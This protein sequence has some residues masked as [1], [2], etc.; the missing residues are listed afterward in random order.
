MKYSR[1]KA[2][3]S[4][5]ACSNTDDK[6]SFS[7]YADRKV[8]TG[9]SPPTFS[10]SSCPKRLTEVYA[11]H[12]HVQSQ[13]CEQVAGRLHALPCA[14]SEDPP[15][16]LDAPDG[17]KST[18]SMSETVSDGTENSEDCTICTVFSAV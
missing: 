15:E 12:A 7:T 18:V 8:S 11:G 3:M 9:C 4:F 5:G 13:S 17:K 16:P 10:A 6:K 14:E 2:K 1:A